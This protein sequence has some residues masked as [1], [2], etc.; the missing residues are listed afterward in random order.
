MDRE[1]LNYLLSV[2]KRSHCFLCRS[3]VYMSLGV[4]HAIAP[5][6]AQASCAFASRATNPG[7]DRGSYLVAA[8]IL[9]LLSAA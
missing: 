1:T 6:P 2:H 5:V 8:R 9:S 3:S 7:L 4:A